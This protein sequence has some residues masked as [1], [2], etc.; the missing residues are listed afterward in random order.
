MSSYQEQEFDNR[1]IEAVTGVKPMT[2]AQWEARGIYTCE[3]RRRAEFDQMLIM[4]PDRP[5]RRQRA[6]E[7]LKRLATGWRRYVIADLLRISILTALQGAG[8]K[9]KEA[10]HTAMLVVLPEADQNTQ[11]GGVELMGRLAAASDP[12]EYL[13]FV[14]GLAHM[15]NPWLARDPRRIARALGFAGERAAVALNLSGIRRRVL[16]QLEA[17][18]SKAETN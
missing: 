16:E 10:G 7:T 9:A 11:P 15:D 6:G 2:I 14:P 18:E 1:I 12:D 4:A 3:L 8:V 5:D 17:L 13:I